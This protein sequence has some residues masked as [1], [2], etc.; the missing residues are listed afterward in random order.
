MGHYA[1]FLFAEPSFWEG[2]SR[3]VDLANALNVYNESLT[4]EQADALAMW[5]DWSAV[6]DDI[7]RAIRR[8]KKRSRGG[9]LLQEAGRQPCVER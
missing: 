4:P 6:G 7:R 9:G 1:R 2:A 3:V 8:Y 5:A